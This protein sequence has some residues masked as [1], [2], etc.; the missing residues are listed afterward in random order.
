MIESLAAA[1]KAGDFVGALDEAHRIRRFVP[2]ALKPRLLILQLVCCI[3]TEQWSKA[4]KL[5][6]AVQGELPNRYVE[7]LRWLIHSRQQGLRPVVREL[8]DLVR[9]GRTDLRATLQRQRIELAHEQ[10]DS[11]DLNLARLTIR[12]AAKLG[13]ADSKL[14]RS[15]VMHGVAFAARAGDWV[16]VERQLKDHPKVAATALMKDW[17]GILAARRGDTPAVLRYLQDRGPGPAAN[18]VA[19]QL[20]RRLLD[21][22]RYRELLELAEPLSIGSWPASIAPVRVVIAL[23]DYYIGDPKRALGTL[24]GLEP[25]PDIGNTAKRAKETI[26]AEEQLAERKTAARVRADRSTLDIGFWTA[27]LHRDPARLAD[28]LSSD[29]LANIQDGELRRKAHLLAGIASVVTGRGTERALELLKDAPPGRFTDQ[30][31]A[32]CS[33][34]LGR[35]AALQVL[36]P[37]TPWADVARILLAREA[38]EQEQFESALSLLDEIPADS[39]QADAVARERT[40]VSFARVLRPVQRGAFIAARAELSALGHR[41]DLAQEVALLADFTNYADQ[42]RKADSMDEAGR[43]T[44]AKRLV[45]QA[46]S[47]PDRALGQRRLVAAAFGIR[48]ATVIN[49]V[50]ERTRIVQRLRSEIESALELCPGHP[51]GCLM[52]ACLSGPRASVGRTGELLNVAY[53]GGLE[54]PPCL[55]ST[56]VEWYR[57][58]GRLLDLKHYAVHRANRWA[59]DSV[60]GGLAT[61]LDRDQL[62][63]LALS[64]GP[65]ER[66]PLS[67]EAVAATL[68]RVPLQRRA[69]GL[70]H[71][72]SEGETHQTLGS[73]RTVK[74]MMA[75]NQIENELPGF[76]L[77]QL[78]M[79]LD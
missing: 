12:R 2:A 48:A 50:G 26:D 44:L 51:A 10:A 18:A 75:T 21:E 6:E 62:L 24:T 77:E 27:L 61:V 16:A 20:A 73:L 5:L 66:E 59:N 31:R 68:A 53:N 4:E 13:L 43:H 55:E 65:P 39:H 25:Q 57:T 60:A 72:L 76:E 54:P 33:L 8:E 23:V 14:S 78:K 19:T 40:L 38:C 29:V 67:L 11:G 9:S 46:R 79:W 17:A 52:L 41:D 22:K 35:P 74:R 69:L 56:L 7:G 42:F 34:D 70:L 63:E 58:Q 3:R 36:L 37:D 30:L 15:L 64:G 47:S 28:L 71:R 49:N 32:Y 45:R 1:Y